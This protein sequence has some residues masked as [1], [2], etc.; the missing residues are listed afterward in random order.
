MLLTKR[1]SRC[2]ETKRASEF[3][4][5]TKW[6]DGTPRTWQSRCKVCHRAADRERLGHRSLEERRASG[7]SPL[8][9]ARRRR[10]SK[11]AWDERNVERKRERQ[12]EAASQDRA[13]RRQ[14]RESKIDRVVL[15]LRTKGYEVE[16]RRTKNG[17]TT[18]L[19]A[20][21]EGEE[22][23][24]RFAYPNAKPNWPNVRAARERERGAA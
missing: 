16:R 8:E 6:P 23:V 14:E 7:L 3:F 21:A 18:R 9:A 10:E 22:R 5:K 4:A 17:T 24:F 11:R 13:V 20:R 1:C 12:R 2:G 19:V 15:L